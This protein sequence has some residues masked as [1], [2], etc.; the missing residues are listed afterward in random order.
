MSW[1]D[2]IF[3]RNQERRL[4]AA[5]IDAKIRQIQNETIL[6]EREPDGCWGDN[7]NQCRC[8]EAPDCD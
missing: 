6:I 5:M 1:L 4:M 2:Y 8:D 7:C 3:K